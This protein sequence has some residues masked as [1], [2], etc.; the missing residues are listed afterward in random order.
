MPQLTTERLVLV[1]FRVELVQAAIQSRAELERHLDARVHSEWPNRDF[2]EILPFLAQQLTEDPKLLDWSYLIV[3]ST[4]RIVIGEIGFKGKPNS[5]G[6]VEIG[7]GIVPSYQGRGFA[8]EA[9][10]ALV[11]WALS[12]PEV[13]RVVAECLISNVPSIR[14]LEKVGMRRSGVDGEMVKWE[15]ISGGGRL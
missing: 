12:H 1:P 5:E 13:K 14:V 15:T 11:Q 2:G 6:V 10:S 4:D 9:A 7:Y 3:A 8:T